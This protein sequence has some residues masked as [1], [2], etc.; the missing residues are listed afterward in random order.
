MTDIPKGAQGYYLSLTKLISCKLMQHF[1]SE[2]CYYGPIQE[3]DLYTEKKIWIFDWVIFI[4]IKRTW[5]ERQKYLPCGSKLF[6]IMKV[7]DS[8]T[9]CKIHFKIRLKIN[10]KDII[11][12]NTHS[13]YLNQ[14]EQMSLGWRGSTSEAIIVPCIVIF[15]VVRRRITFIFHISYYLSGRLGSSM[16][17]LTALY[18]C[19]LSGFSQR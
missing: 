1:I 11:V 16:A 6:L 14:V 19:F 15:M 8:I 17:L 18:S 2:R 10:T 9:W 3:S 4:C 7:F 13:S 12:H 5:L